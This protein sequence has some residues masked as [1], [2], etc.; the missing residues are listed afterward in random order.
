MKCGL[1]KISKFFPQC[2]L[3]LLLV[4]FG[5][6]GV[7][8]K[9][10]SANIVYDSQDTFISTAWTGITGFSCDDATKALGAYDNV[11]AYCSIAGIKQ[12]P[13]GNNKWWGVSGLPQGAIVDTVIYTLKGYASSTATQYKKEWVFANNTVSYTFLPNPITMSTSS[14]YYYSQLDNTVLNPTQMATLTQ[15]NFDRIT[16]TWDGF[17]LT[18]N[19]AGTKYLY[20]DGLERTIWYHYDDA[21]QKSRINSFT[22]SPLGNGNNG[23]PYVVSATSTITTTYY[24]N[25][26]YDSAT[27]TKYTK[28]NY[29]LYDYFTNQTQ[30]W[31]PPI[32]ANT[33]YATSTLTNF[34]ASG[35]FNCANGDTYQLAVRFSNA[36][37][38][39]VSNWFPTSYY[40]AY[41]AYTPTP[42]ATTSVIII[43]S[44]GGYDTGTTTIDVNDMYVDC[45]LTA[46]QG[47][48]QNALI[49]AFVPSSGAIANY[50][51]FTTSMTT[52]APMGYFT[53]VKNNLNGLNS[54]SSPAFAVVIPAHLKTY[55]FTPF[56][57]AIAGILWFFF[58]VHF[59]KRLKTITV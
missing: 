55:I 53:V 9:N 38:S 23:N 16:T 15:A 50:Y 46:L 52:K 42:T 35:G 47:C 27:S 43:G 32:T 40:F 59:Y 25:S 28:L 19:N 57:T 12:A 6:F 33:T 48:F 41:I 4:L 5:G 2:L 31:S 21:L 29:R 8:L 24:Y 34:C 49:W 51:N 56:D 17:I 26:A 36:D 54:T 44:G 11:Y 58:A 1:L 10:A 14:A 39:V 30:Y 18:N 13:I 22:I 20:I 45:G 37:G 3:L 7:G